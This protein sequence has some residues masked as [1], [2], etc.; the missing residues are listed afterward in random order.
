MP[1]PVTR[2]ILA[3]ISCTAAISGKVISSTHPRPMPY[4]APTC[5]YVAMP[6]GS[7]SDAPVIR[8]GPIISRSFGCSGCLISE[9]LG[10]RRSPADALHKNGVVVPELRRSK[11][12]VSRLAERQR[13]DWRGDG[14]L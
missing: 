4:C 1:Q 5:E 12:G 7:S 14:R 9:G 3:E 2:P 8:P 10:I 11:A 6:D 13:L